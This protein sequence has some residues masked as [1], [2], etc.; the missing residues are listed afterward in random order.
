M[1]EIKKIS[2]TQFCIHYDVPIS[3]IENLNNYELIQI[4]TI[5]NSTY[6]DLDQ[7]KTIEKLMRLHYHLNINFEG[8]D[9][10][11]NL[12]DQIEHLQNEITSLNNK[13]EFYL[14]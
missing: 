10:V 11:I 3:F 4:I 14:K 5:N 9:V 13:L 12:L 7:I 1:K 2:V 8:L 6:I